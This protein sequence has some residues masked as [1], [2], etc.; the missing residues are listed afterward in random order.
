LVFRLEPSQSI[1][2]GHQGLKPRANSALDPTSAQGLIRLLSR[3]S[4]G[5]KRLSWGR[6]AAG[7]SCCQLQTRFSRSARRRH[8]PDRRQRDF[9]RHRSHVSSLSDSTFGRRRQASPRI[10]GFSLRH[11][12]VRSRQTCGTGRHSIYVAEPCQVSVRGI[13]H[14]RPTSGCTRLR[15]RHCCCASVILLRVAGCAGEPQVRW[16]AAQPGVNSRRDSRGPRG[17]VTRQIASSS[18]SRDTGCA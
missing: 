3:F 10:G 11:L 18:I 17:N 8:T 7:Q 4:R 2:F 5:P 13:E 15:P 9:A 6:W 14:G 1:V 12:D 16:A